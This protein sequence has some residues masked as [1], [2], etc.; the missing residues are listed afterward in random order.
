VVS[1][2]KKLLQKIAVK[3]RKY[4]KDYL[5]LTMHRKKF[6]IEEAK[7]GINFIG[8]IIRPW[9]RYASNRLVNNA[10]FVFAGTPQDIESHIQRLN[11]YMGFLAHS[12]TYAIRWRLYLTITKETRDKI[13]CVNMRKYRLRDSFDNTLLMAS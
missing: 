7:K 3:A 4:L 5:G 8:C 10:L 2:D 9:G 1:R 11:S 6:S 13:V 12:K